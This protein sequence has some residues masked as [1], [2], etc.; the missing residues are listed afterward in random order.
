[1]YSRC[2]CVHVD[3]YRNNWVIMAE[4]GGFP[5]AEETNY[6]QA[7][8]TQPFLEGGGGVHVDVYSPCGCV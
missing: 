6:N 1:M 2:G 5:I 3:V 7:E 4:C 8:H